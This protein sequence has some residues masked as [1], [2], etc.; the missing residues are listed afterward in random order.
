MLK[1]GPQAGQLVPGSFA[2]FNLNGPIGKGRYHCLVCD[3]K[4]N[5]VVMVFARE[6]ADGKDKTVSD[7]LQRLDQALAKDQEGYLKSFV[8]YLSPAAASSVTDA[9]ITDPD[10]LVAEAA[11]RDALLDRLAARAT[12][13]KH[14]VVSTYPAAGPRGYNLNP[15]AE[16]TVI[17]YVKHKVT[18]NFAFGE[19]ALNEKGIDEI[20]QAVDTLSGKVRRKQPGPKKKVPAEAPKAA[21]A[22]GVIFRL[23]DHLEITALPIA[24]HRHRDRV[25]NLVLF[26]DV[27]HLLA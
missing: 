5:P 18:N 22:A 10:R 8:V 16:V 11:A 24:Q 12:K 26:Q 4:L 25:A 6:R 20:L 13:L 2:P 17:L 15:K 3:Y 1:S 27:V 23:Q 9:K 14:V 7:L 19:G 21:S